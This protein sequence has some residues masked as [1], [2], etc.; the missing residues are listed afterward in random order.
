MPRRR[1]GLSDAQISKLPRTNKRRFV[2]D[3]EQRNLYYRLPKHHGPA[4]FV[5]II[6]RHGKQQWKVLGRADLITVEAARELTRQ[7]IRNVRDGKPPLPPAPPPPQSVS[8]VCE[9]WLKRVVEAGGYRTAPEKARIVRRYVAPRLGGLDF[10]SMRRSDVALALDDIQDRCGAPM[11]DA[12]L[13]VLRAVCHWWESRDDTFRSP[14]AR[15]MTRTPKDQRARARI[16]TDDELRRIWRTAEQDT[17]FFGSF[18][19]LLLLTAVRFSKLQDLRWD[20]ID[21]NGVWTIRRQPREKN[22]PAKLQLPPLALAIIARQ[23]RLA[24]SSRVFPKVHTRLKETF[25]RTAG[26]DGWTLHDCRRMARSLMSRA[27]VISEHAEKALGHVRGGVESIYD[28][29]EYFEQINHALE[30]L[31]KLILHIV[32]APEGG[33]VVP[34]QA[35]Q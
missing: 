33:N 16:L 7:A 30:R 27:G 28:R 35:A 34:L 10:V 15:N 3:V 25:A 1:K 20:D 22:C 31:S 17:K 6:K 2:A 32:N 13:N 29:H 26:V 23:P 24:G 19:Q 8:A 18:I 4:T 11:A 12:T 21:A 14:I 5:A 9:N